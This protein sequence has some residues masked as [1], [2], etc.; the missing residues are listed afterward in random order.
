MSGYGDVKAKKLLRFLRSLKGR[1]IELSE[2]GKHYKVTYI[3][4]G[5]ICPVPASHMTINKYIVKDV[6]EKL[7]GWGIS[8]KEEF[9][10]GIK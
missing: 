9:D 5:E 6:C 8:S 1:G 2:G 7:V 3:Y 4:T 10:K